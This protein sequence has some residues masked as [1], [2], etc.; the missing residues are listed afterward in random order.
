[1][2]AQMGLV[3]AISG[4]AKHAVIS[5]VVM[6][7]AGV[8]A[9]AAPFVA[10]VSVMLLIGVLLLVGGL[11]QCFLAFKAGAF[12]RG[13]LILLLGVLTAAAGVWT[14][15]EPL[16]ALASV[17]LLLAAYFVVS[18][19]LE[20]FATFSGEREPG[21]GWLGFSAVVSMLLGIMLWRQFPLSGVWAVG[22]LVGIRLLMAGAS[23]VA[24][25][26][27]VRKGV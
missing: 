21:R 11:A 19:A 10:G 3:G 24:I 16:G 22:T 25:G 13:L 23:L 5:G 8:L 12:G 9:V 7:I 27:A 14:L 6:V 4:R 1:M 2:S 15:R 17:T 20:L 18:G 26:S